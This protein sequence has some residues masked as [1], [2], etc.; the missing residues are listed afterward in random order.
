VQE[1]WIIVEKATSVF[2][3]ANGLPFN[4]SYQGSFRHAKERDLDIDDFQTA[5]QELR[6]LRNKAVHATDADITYS[7]AK[8][9]K[10]TANFIAAELSMRS[11]GA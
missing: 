5:Y 7:T 8:Q 6:L 11:H 9:Y 1:A 2:C 4:L 3:K 10:K